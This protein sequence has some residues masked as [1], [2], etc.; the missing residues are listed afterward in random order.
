MRQLSNFILLFYFFIS[1]CSKSREA[2]VEKNKE[3]QRYNIQIG[4]AGNK[5][6]KLILQSSLEAERTIVSKKESITSAFLYAKVGEYIKLSIWLPAAGGDIR[7]LDAKNVQLPTTPLSGFFEIFKDVYFLAFDANNAI[8]N[9]FAYKTGVAKLASEVLVGK[10][11]ILQKHYY[12]ENGVE[13]PTPDIG[14]RKD[15]SYIMHAYPTS[16][17]NLNPDVFAASVEK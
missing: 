3:G 15:D 14:C 5:E 12:L 8:K 1:A 9:P 17:A 6:G 2:D 13:S 11:F 16:I 4:N 10:T 7:V